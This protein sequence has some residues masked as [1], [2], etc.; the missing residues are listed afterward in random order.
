M[1]VCNWEF[2]ISSHNYFKSF[3]YI[4]CTLSGTWRSACLFHICEKEKG[5]TE[6]QN[7]ITQQWTLKVFQRLQA[8]DRWKHHLELSS[9]SKT[10]LKSKNN[11]QK[12]VSESIF[13]TYLIR[14]YFSYLQ[15]LIQISES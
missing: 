3:V 9:S 7:F 12:G 15:E 5:F 13:L 8:D 6:N 14:K 4:N 1:Q 10:N 2:L 11:Q